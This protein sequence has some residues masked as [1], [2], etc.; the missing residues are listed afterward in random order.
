MKFVPLTSEADPMFSK[1]M[2][3][4]KGSFPSHEQR[5][6]ASQREILTHRA[7]HFDLLYEGSCFVGILLYWETPEFYY[8]EHFCMEPDVRGNGYG[9]TA[10]ALLGEKGKTVILEIDPPVD[11]LSNRRKSFY[12]RAGYHENSFSHVHPPYHPG[13]QGHLLCVM[14]FPR[15]LTQT[16]YDGF[17]SYLC[18]TVMS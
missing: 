12:E 2:N 5:E 14:S 7:Y 3:L 9:Q 8:V 15:P 13:N 1:A 16:E 10:L 18:D 6:S 4:Y 11:E 17:F